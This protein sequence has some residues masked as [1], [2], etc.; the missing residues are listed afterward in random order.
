MCAG[1]GQSH[2]WLLNQ[3]AGQLARG[4]GL[5]GMDA[6]GKLALAA[7]DGILYWSNYSC[8]RDAEMC[9]CVYAC[10]SRIVCRRR[11]TPRPPISPGKASTN[12][13]G[14][15]L[16]WWDGSGGRYGQWDR[17]GFGSGHGSSGEPALR[18]AARVASLHW[19]VAAGAPAPALMMH[20]HRGPEL[21]WGIWRDPSAG[22]DSPASSLGS[23]TALHRKVSE[24]FVLVCHY[25]WFTTKQVIQIVVNCLKTFALW[26]CR[27]RKQSVNVEKNIMENNVKYNLKAEINNIFCQ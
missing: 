2:R 13:K 16:Y 7:Q 8:W 17:W 10:V 1:E 19:L 11:P 6:L 21:G 18:D 26:Y 3:M 12:G 5:R 4:G 22:W 20:P 14:P 24:W 23:T 15:G 27:N 25:S 9:V